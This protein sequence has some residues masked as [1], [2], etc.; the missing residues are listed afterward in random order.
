[1]TRIE[2]SVYNTSLSLRRN[3]DSTL[4]GTDSITLTNQQSGGT[5]PSIY[6]ALVDEF[7]QYVGSDSSSTATISIVS[8]TTGQTYTPTIVGTT[9]QTASRGMF[10]FSSLVFTAEPN[11]TFS[12]SFS[13]T[14]IDSSKPSNSVYLSNLNTTDTSLSFSVSLRE[15]EIGEAFLDSGACEQCAA[16]SSYSLTTMSSPGD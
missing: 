5:M 2:E 11:K 15:C 8:S 13:T 16:N 1:M 14:G 4:S 12:L 7:G 10:A 9:T 3:L 6:L